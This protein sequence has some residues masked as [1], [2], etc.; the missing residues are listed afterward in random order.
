M[1][2]TEQPAPRTKWGPLELASGI[3]SLNA[4]AF[5][6]ASFFAIGLIAF[7]NVGQSYVLREMVGLDRGEFGQVTGLLQVTSE[8]IAI[9]LMDGDQPPQT[10]VLLIIQTTC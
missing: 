3:S 10:K 9:I 1:A 6:F 8:V 7:F 5:M 4:W 2:Q